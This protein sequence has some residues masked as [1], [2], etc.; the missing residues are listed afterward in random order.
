MPI[1]DG[2]NRWWF[3]LAIGEVH[4]VLHL[5]HKKSS[6]VSVLQWENVAMISA[7]KGEPHGV[8]TE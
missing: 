8:P 5:L 2:H 1:E 3:G 4:G 7:M 6:A